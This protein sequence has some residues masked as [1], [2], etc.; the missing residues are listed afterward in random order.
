MPD[1]Y[2][3]AQWYQERPE[4]EQSW[5][6][7]LRPRQVAAGPAARTAIAFAIVTADGQELPV[8]GAGAEDLVGALVGRSV[9]AT[10]KLV[11]LKAEGYGEELWLARIAAAS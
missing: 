8:Y 6:G 7:E 9:V 3:H 10:G 1:V 2:A 4:R 11:D 5:H